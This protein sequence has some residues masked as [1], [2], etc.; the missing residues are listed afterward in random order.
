M[1]RVYEQ[2]KD[3]VNSLFC[4]GKA[5]QGIKKNSGKYKSIVKYMDEFKEFQA[6]SNII[7]ERIAL[8]KAGQLKVEDPKKTE[9]L[10]KNVTEAFKVIDR[11]DKVYAHY[12]KILYSYFVNSIPCDLSPRNRERD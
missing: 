5:L 10:K 7:A 9:I 2:R 1:G 4:Y 11:Y 12:L 8:A 6:K 3:I